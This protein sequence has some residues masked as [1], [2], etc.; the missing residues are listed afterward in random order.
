MRAAH[1]RTMKCKIL[2]TKYQSTTESRDYSFPAYYNKKTGCS[3]RKPILKKGFERWS[4][5]ISHRR[6]TEELP[7]RGLK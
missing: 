4:I 2:R 5:N 7:R 1:K 6:L 3:I